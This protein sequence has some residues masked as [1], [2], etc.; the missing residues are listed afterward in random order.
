MIQLI[1]E[2]REQIQQEAAERVLAMLQ[3]HPTAILGLATGSTPVGIYQEIVKLYTQGLI[4]FK[5][6]TTFNLDEYI[7]LPE[8]HPQSYHTYM[9]RNLFDHIDLPVEQAYIPNGNAPDLMEEC[10]RYD[11]LINKANQMDLQI[12]GLG[13]NGHIGFN[14]PADSLTNGTHIVELREQ[15]RLANARFF[16]TLDEVPTHA[17]TMGMG[18]ILKAKSILLVVYGEEKA[19]VAFKA[20]TGPIQTELPASLLQIHPNLTVLMDKEAGRLFND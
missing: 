6:A 10:L 13:H 14:E 4:S 18:S 11:E 20:L 5:K 12:L 2:N 16:H 8:T 15:T 17:I 3:E 19:E 9:K 1:F 7:G